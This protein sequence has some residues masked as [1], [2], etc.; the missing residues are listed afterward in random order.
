M[1]RTITA[2]LTL[3]CCA[4]FCAGGD[5]MLV[6]GTV[7]PLFELKSADGT[8]YRL[9]DYAGKSYV[10]LIFYPGDETPVCTKQLCE[11]RDEYAAFGSRNAVVFGVNPAAAASHQKFSGKHGLQ[12]PLLI[13][14][15]N[16]VA[17]AY[18]TKAPVMNKRTV[19]V[20]DKEGKVIFAQR[21]K[22]PVSEILSSIPAPQ[23]A[24]IDLKLK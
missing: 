6:V 3:F 22:P 11:I 19:Y 10:V 17:A 9:A 7:A 12:F 18:G 16:T 23:G 5:T 20:I 8:L 21:G 2:L 14:E 13:D 1:N 15:K 24:T 4:V